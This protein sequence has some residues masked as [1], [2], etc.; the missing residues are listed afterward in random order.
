MV[1][2]LVIEFIS[3]EE[4]LYIKQQKKLIRDPRGIYFKDSMTP[5]IRDIYLAARR[6]A[7]AGGV[8]M[9]YLK[10]GRVFVTKNDG[11]ETRI[12]CKE[13]LTQL[14]EPSHNVGATFGNVGHTI[15][16]ATGFANNQASSSR[17]FI[18]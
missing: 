10:R 9:A 4:K 17:Q 16:P 13:D 18:Q 2:V 12:H 1:Y 15:P 3:V 7:K 5:I 8:R 11:T 6:I 14:S